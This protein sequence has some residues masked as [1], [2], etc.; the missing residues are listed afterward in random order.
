MSQLSYIKTI[1]QLHKEYAVVQAKGEDVHV[2]TKQGGKAFI[3][4]H[5]QMNGAEQGF[6]VLSRHHIRKGEGHA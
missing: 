2:S 6:Y 5:V 4:R 1:D 3:Y